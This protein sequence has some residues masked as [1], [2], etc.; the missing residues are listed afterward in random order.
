ANFP[1]LLPK[2]SEAR[3]KADERSEFRVA[4]DLAFAFF[5]VTTRLGQKLPRRI[6]RKRDSI[7][8][9]RTK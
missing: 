4:F 1:S 5:K 9:E 6:E 7:E 8:F 2:S 3:K